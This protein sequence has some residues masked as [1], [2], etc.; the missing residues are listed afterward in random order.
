MLTGIDTA[1]FYFVNQTI[2]NVFLDALMIFATSF[3][4]GKLIFAFAII[5]TLFGKRHAR[6]SGILILAGLTVT[7]YCVNFLKLLVARP[8]PFLTLENVNV[9][10]AC[11]NFSFPSYHAAAAFMAAA[12]LSKYFKRGYIFY[13]LA[14]LVAVSRVYLGVH[15][16]SDVIA[17]GL[18]G[19]L[20]GYVLVY[21]GRKADI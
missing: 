7:F 19:A 5:M 20:L 8:R 1:V 17:G 15:Y 11:D 10:F 12:V 2:H 21:F 16:P 14:V 6:T 3:G 4:D 13:I 18:V 9:L